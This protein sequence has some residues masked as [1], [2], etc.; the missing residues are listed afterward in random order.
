MDGKNNSMGRFEPWQNFSIKMAGVC[1][2]NVSFMC[3]CTYVCSR[4]YVRPHRPEKGLGSLVPE[5]A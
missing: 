5:F 3:M 2:F 1:N 4:A